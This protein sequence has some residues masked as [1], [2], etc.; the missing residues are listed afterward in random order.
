MSLP[1]G[2]YETLLPPTAAADLLIYLYFS[3]GAKEAAEG[4]TVFS[5]ASGGT[6]VG[7]RLSEL[8]VT[9]RSDPG[10]P[11]LGS[12]PFVIA[13]TSSQDMSVFDNGLPITATSW[14][15]NGELAALQSSRYS[16][17]LAGLPVTPPASNLALEMHGA[18]ASL[19]DM[20]A[21][22]R[23]GPGCC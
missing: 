23:R 16:A 14:I 9:L 6:R 15:S 3:M 2:R 20:I 12:A 5:K 18:S 8:P 4:R 7:E 21:S 10:L 11:G 19:P 13:H 22:T 17:S 1:A